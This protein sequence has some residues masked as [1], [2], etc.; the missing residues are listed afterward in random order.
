M[1]TSPPTPP[2]ML[3]SPPPPRMQSAPPFPLIVSA[4]AVPRMSSLFPVP[5]QVPLA[6]QMTMVVR[7]RA[8]HSVGLSALAL[9]AALR[10]ARRDPG[11]V[12]LAATAMA[13]LTRINTANPRIKYRNGILLIMR[14]PP[15]LHRWR[16]TDKRSQRPA[17]NKHGS[18]PSLHAG[19]GGH[20][21]LPS[22][23][24]RPS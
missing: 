10:L 23:P 11:T 1:Q 4:I 12:L 24:D 6:G 19:W 18:D 5:L 3:S 17:Q 8:A 13:T 9:I 21:F 2:V 14:F 22:W 15:D 7:L 16:Y 20:P